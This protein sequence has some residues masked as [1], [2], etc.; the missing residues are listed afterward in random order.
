MRV[1]RR[2][3]LLAGAFLAGSVA[4][5][6][7]GDPP[8]AAGLAVIGLVALLVGWRFRTMEPG[9]I[10]SGIAG[11]AEILSARETGTKVALGTL[12]VE[13]TATVSIAGF[14]PYEATFRMLLDPSQVASVGPGAL[15]PVR[16]EAGEPTRVV[17]DTARG[18]LVP[19]MP[20]G[21][22]DRSAPRLSADAIVEHGVAVDGTLHFSGPT[23]LVAR[24]LVPHL[25]GPDA[26]DPIHQAVISF[27][28]LGAKRVRTELLVRVPRGSVLPERPGSPLPITYLP[29]D[30]SI[31]TIDWSRR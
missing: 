27:T 2:F 20:F 1:A 6:A 10:R 19:P 31:A 18:A 14:D 21:G 30:P 9:S 17:L 24:D 4:A 8:V 13:V 3:L 22:S 7:T 5:L 23:G 16:V 11:T 28:P 26:D 29:D 15:I 25:R 12:V